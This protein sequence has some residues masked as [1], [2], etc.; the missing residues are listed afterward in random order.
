[1]EKLQTFEEIEGIQENLAR[2]FSGAPEAL[3]A[4]ELQRGPT[5]EDL[6]R[7][8]KEIELRRELVGFINDE[9]VRESALLDIYK[10]QLQLQVA[11]GK[12]TEVNAQRLSTAAENYLG[13]RE[14]DRERAENDRIE[15]ERIRSE[16]QRLRDTYRIGREERNF[17]TEIARGEGPL[18]ALRERHRQENEAVLF[19]VRE[20]LVAVETGSSEHIEIVNA[21]GRRLLFLRQTQGL[22]ERDL[23]QQQQDARLSILQSYEDEITDHLTRAAERQGDLTQVVEL[24]RTAALGRLRDQYEADLRFFEANELDKTDLVRLYEAQRDAIRQSYDQQFNDTLLRTRDVALTTL[25]SIADTIANGIERFDDN[26]EGWFNTLNSLF[27]LAQQ[28]VQLASTFGTLSQ[29]GGIGGF[30]RGLFTSPDSGPR[31]SSG[32]PSFH[33]GG[34]IPGIPGRDT[35]IR[36]QP[37]ETV[38]PRGTAPVTITL[39]MPM[40]NDR[41]VRSE[42]MAMLPAIQA[43][44]TNAWA[45]SR[46]AT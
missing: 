11:Q 41:N 10:N 45:Q 7:W 32:I 26:T 18:A 14:L 34:V 3:A 43:G 5:P 2:L 19:A 4:V 17:R 39:N 38:L 13:I 25:G 40:V 22:Q 21:T 24:Q 1:M 6:E 28:F 37:G 23:I 15:Q 16:R 44:V 29:G 35:L 33:Q 27:Q 30:L 20:Q 12:Q 42:V 36:A 8:E 31:G 9:S 46:L